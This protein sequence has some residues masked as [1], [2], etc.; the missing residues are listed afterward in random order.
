[1][2]LR[3]VKTRAGGV[4][5]VMLLSVL[6]LSSSAVADFERNP[7][8]YSSTQVEAVSG[9]GSA[10]SDVAADWGG[11]AADAAG[12]AND[13]NW[14][15]T[16]LTASASW[17]QGGSSGAFSYTYDMRVP[18]ASGP[19][20][21][22]ALSYSSAEHDGRTSGS[23]NQASIVGDGWSYSPSFIERTYTSCADDKDGNQGDDPTGDRCWDGESPSIT[24][25]LDGVGTSLVKDDTTGKW[26]AAD[27]DNWRVEY[28][29]SPA[30][31][32]GV[33][34]EQ[35]KITTTDGTVHHFGS[36]AGSRWTVPVFGNHSGEACYKSGNFKGSRC[37]Q[38]YRWVLDKSVDVFGNFARYTYQT[39]N[40]RYSPAVD[41]DTQASFIRDGWLQRIEY[42]LRTNA[43]TVT[44]AKVEFTMADRCLSDCRESN[45]DPKKSK[46]PDTP[47][48]VSCKAGSTCEE[49]SPAF[50]SAKRLVGVTTYVG[51][52]GAY[53]TVDSWAL[54]HEFK[55]YGDAE[56][57]VL[58]LAAVKH[59]GHVGGTATT[60]AVEFGGTFLPNR[61][62]T[63]ESFPGIWR[64]RLTSIKGETGGVTTINY[65]EPECGIGNMPSSAH[66]NSRRCFPSRYTP[67][68]LSEPVDVYFH[69]YVVRSIAE[70]DATGAGETVWRFYDY[71][72]DGGGTGALWAWNDAE[73]VEKKD[74]DWNQWRG[75]AQV[76]TRVGDPA[77]PGPQMRSRARYYRGLD[78]DR[79]PGGEKRSV[80]VTDTAGNTATDHRALSGME[81]ETAS[82]DDTTPIGTETSWYWTSRTAKRSYEGGV[83]EA[84]L[85]GERRTDTRTL[86]APSVWRTART[87]TA[88]DGYGRAISV[89]SMGD[90]AKSGDERCVRTTYADNTSVW[91]LDLMSTVESVSVGC[92]APVNRPADLIGAA[93]AYYDYSDSLT[94]QPKQGLMTRAEALESWSGGPVY[95][96]VGTSTFDALG[97][98]LNTTDALGNLTKTAYTPEGGGPVTSTVTTNALGHV[99]TTTLAP[100]WGETTATLEPHSRRTVVALDPLGRRTAV[101]LPGRDPASEGANLK[102]AYNVSA[103]TPTTVTTDKMIHDGSY[104]TSVALYDSLMRERQTQAETY[105]G[106]LITQ[107]VYDSYGRARHSSDAVYNNE[108][109]PNG[110]LVW[111]S[112]NNDVSRTEFVYDG[113]GRVTDEVFVVKGTEKWRTSTRFGGDTKNWMTTVIPPQGGTATSTLDDALGRTVELRQYLDRSGTG[114][115]DKSF[116]AYAGNG[117]LDKVTDPAGNTWEYEYDLRGRRTALHDPDTGTS[118]TTYNAGGQVIASV[119]GNGEA[120]SYEYDR[121]GRPTLTLS[122]TTKLIER[123]YD[124]AENGIGKPWKAT[125]WVDGQAW[126]TENRKYSPE[127]RP[128]QLYTHLPAAAG[129]LAGSYWE[130]FAYNE[131]GSVHTSE[132]KAVGSL[133]SEIMTYSYDEMGRAGRVT[134]WGGDFG[135]GKVYV[136]EAVYSPYGQLLQRRLGDPADVGG[137]SGQV[138]QTWIYEEGTGRLGEFYLDKDTAGEFDATNYGVAALSYRYDQSGNLLSIADDPVHT[139]ERLDPERQCF[140]YDYLGRLTEAWAQAGASGECSAGTVGGPGAY[141]SSY[142]YD[143]VGNRTAETKWTPSGPVEKTYSYAEPGTEQPHAVDE[144]TS[145]GAATA[146]TY[147]QAGFTTGID[148]DGAVDVLNW[149]PTGRLESIESAEG[150]AKFFD[151]ADG[152]RLLRVDADGDITAWV[153]G[154]ELKYTK[155]TSK[156]EATRYYT[157]GGAAVGVRNGLGDILWFAGDHHG[158]N[159]WIVNGDTLTA[160]VQ[161]RDPFGNV[162]GAGADTWPDDR[163]FVGGIENDDV[164]ITTVG[165]R[166]YDP[167][168]GRFLSADP[169]MDLTD[170]QQINGYAY[171]NNAPTVMSDASGLK[172]VKSGSKGGGAKKGKLKKP[173]KNPPPPSGG[174]GPSKGGKGPVRGGRE[175]EPPRQPP[176]GLPDRYDWQQKGPRP[177]PPITYPGGHGFAVD[178]EFGTILGYIFGEMETNAGSTG[179]TTMA[180]CPGG[181]GY[182]SVGCNTARAA[183]WYGKVRPGGPWDHKGPIGEYL[184]V[185]GDDIANQYVNVPGTDYQVRYD[186]WSNIHYGYVG[187]AAGFGASTLIEGASLPG[188]GRSESADDFAMQMG[189]DL[190]NE[191]GDDMTEAD[192]EAFIVDSLGDLHDLEGN[193]VQGDGTAAMVECRPGLASC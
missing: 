140:R 149:A 118:T 76:V 53:S 183:W 63:G 83:I 88:F 93:R 165:A 156:I 30:T 13:G 50:F 102:F 62:D 171:G 129:A 74:R 192:L 22:L 160:T 99:T 107:T 182:A 133:R 180:A 137:T 138:W 64:P 184:G 170:P 20:P 35:W 46:W 173:K 49:Y 56:Q 33:S 9:A 167:T 189:I 78:G 176:K 178:K 154:Y 98:E 18:P 66:Q 151:N 164:G 68:G 14:A 79:L 38:V 32:G 127:G 71:S 191:Y 28:S 94:A 80:T 58:W 147:D 101:W 70:S 25:T 87:E 175:A 3:H 44:T 181:G 6:V 172:S 185:G 143:K 146:F 36:V 122:G 85:T 110:K 48:D 190:W 11:G 91:L 65:T 96:T 57:V 69:K 89:D 39:E 179:T 43:S 45:G 15:A 59:T 77:D 1:M 10:F 162:R 136:D 168:V 109:G 41:S 132:A 12:D 126:T 117:Q 21:A 2:T 121:L 52:N 29:G 67:E 81:W 174:Q 115:S 152:Q 119:D 134:G 105:G 159:Q 37:D 128:T 166:E 8:S 163:G 42:G 153:A 186:L 61:V 150:T 135:F 7:Q 73:F 141:R 188:A 157:H 112:R 4:T 116:Y 123:S 72:T 145:T 161:R 148:R 193:S 111:I 158:T 97:R 131:D 82:Y 95:K 104:V 51:A 155:A 90:V 26:R 86:L 54:T 47:W 125:R 60:P 31:A 19:V 169:I 27:D 16:D 124:G 187:S 24:V 84:W 108:S 100:A 17:A 92:T 34:T 142:G 114:A 55:N 103:T 23:N 120:L 5:G 75:Y 144:V 106:R 40:G 113:A 139:S 177:G 130:A